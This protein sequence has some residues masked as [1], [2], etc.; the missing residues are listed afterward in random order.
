MSR[1]PKN[2]PGGLDPFVPPELTKE[3]LQEFSAEPEVQQE[4]AILL[5]VTMT[6]LLVLLGFYVLQWA[7]QGASSMTGGCD[8]AAPDRQ[9]AR[10]QPRSMPRTASPPAVSGPHPLMPGAQPVVKPFSQT[11][12]AGAAPISPVRPWPGQTVR[13]SPT[14]PR[15]QTGAPQR[16]IVDV[17]R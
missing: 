15:P 16:P 13:P 7:G 12:P 10:H 8:G 11:P 6:A 14:A 3:Q 17:T 5:A 1:K 2:P 4:R 9:P